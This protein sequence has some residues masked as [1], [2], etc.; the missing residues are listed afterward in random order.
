[1]TLDTPIDPFQSPPGFGAG[2]LLAQTGPL[3]FLEVPDPA[4][5]P[6]PSTLSHVLLESPLS[7][8]IVLVAIALVAYVVLNARARFKQGLAVAGACVLAAGA[9]WVLAAVVTTDH[10]RLNRAATDLV[11]A[12][13]AADVDAVDAALAPEAQLMDVPT[14]NALDKRAILAAVESQLGAGAPFEVTE[15]AILEVQ[16]ALDGPRAGRVQV[17]VRVQT[18]GMGIPNISWWGLGLIRG[19]D[20]QWRTVSVRALAI[21]GT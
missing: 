15:H 20:G 8:T 10:E 19:E 7:P 12:V 14:L 16:T 21:R 4:P 1:M 11:D 18:R 9:L 2:T 13:A 5:L 3:S 17:K 6:G